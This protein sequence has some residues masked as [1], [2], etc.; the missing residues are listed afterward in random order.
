[1]TKPVDKHHMVFHVLATIEQFEIGQYAPNI[2]VIRAQRGASANMRAADSAQVGE[3]ASPS[4]QLYAIPKTNN[5][6]PSRYRVGFEWW[7]LSADRSESTLNLSTLNL[8]KMGVLQT[9]AG[10]FRAE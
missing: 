1:M 5:R 7:P 9:F 3:A 4:A 6:R 8:S 2:Y 10:C